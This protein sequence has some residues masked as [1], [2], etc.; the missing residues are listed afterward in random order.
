ML[1]LGAYRMGTD[2]AVDEAV[3]LAPRIEDMLR[4][5]RSE[6]GTMAES[7]GRL[8]LALAGA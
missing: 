5:E 6:Q 8:R 7:F 1:R 3:T 4:Q 2:P